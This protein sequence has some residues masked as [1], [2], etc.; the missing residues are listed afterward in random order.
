MGKRIVA[1]TIASTD[2][3]VSWKEPVEDY[4]PNVRVYVA[5][6]GATNDLTYRILSAPD[7]TYA[8]TWIVEATDA[9]LGK[10]AIVSWRSTD[11]KGT[12]GIDIKNATTNT[13]SQYSIWVVFWR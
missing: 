12:I 9:T 4:G 13:P 1:A 7:S 3:F 10:G 2:D 5:N 6:L 8:G 11:M